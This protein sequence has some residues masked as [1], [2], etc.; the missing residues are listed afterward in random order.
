[1]ML[2]TDEKVGPAINILQ[3]DI[4]Y[5]ICKWVMHYLGS[6]SLYKRLNLIYKHEMIGVVVTCTRY[7]NIIIISTFIAMTAAD[8]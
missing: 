3:L 5:T 2:K 4:L 1:M 7:H 6:Y 8:F